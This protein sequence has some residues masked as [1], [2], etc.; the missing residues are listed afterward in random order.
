MNFNLDL[1]AWQRAAVAM[2]TLI[3]FI[4]ALLFCAVRRVY[5]LSVRCSASVSFQQSAKL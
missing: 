5:A 3:R 2:V 4:I 1:V